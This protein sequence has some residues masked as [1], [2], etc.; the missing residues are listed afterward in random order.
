MTS[1]LIPISLLIRSYI[2]LP[3]AQLTTLTLYIYIVLLIFHFIKKRQITINFLNT[4]VIIYC[5]FALSLQI[6]AMMLSYIEITNGNLNKHPLKQIIVF[7][8][9]MIV[10][11]SYYIVVKVFI[12][13]IDDCRKFLKGIYYAFWIVMGV[14]IIQFIYL[15]T[16]GLKSLVTF[17]GQ[18][19]E[20]HFNRD[21]Y[22]SGSYVQTAGRINGF[23]PEASYLAAQL[24]I[25]FA[26]F[27]IAAIINKFDIFN[28]EKQYNSL[29]YFFMLGLILFFLFFGR[30]STGFVAIGVIIIFL[31]FKLKLKR[32]FIFTYALLSLFFILFIIFKDNTI[33]LEIFNHYL[34]EKDETSSSN[35]LGGT[36]ALILTWLNNFFFGT[37]YGYQDY[38]LFK[39]VPEWSKSNSEYQYVYLKNNY[40]PILSVFLGWFAQFGTIIMIFI[41]IYIFKLIRDI[42]KITKYLVN[43]VNVKYVSLLNTIKDS[44]NLFVI[45]YIVMSLLV[46]QWTD[47]YFI[48]VFFFF[49]VYRQL[50]K[51]YKN[52]ISIS[53]IK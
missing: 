44:A 2:P 10:I 26:P 9:L 6:I 34:F 52:Q 11:F 45:F 41:T 40:Y 33:V 38:Y 21:W 49:V 25:L 43:N 1:F 14:L 12:T 48:V 22:V 18:Y 35:R 47:A 3:V 8:I 32:K 53:N 42:N 37:G 29:K 7:S 5:F 51:G 13:N 27:I 28:W 19:L 20:A 16:G 30:S 39:Y 36:I 15:S 4:K 46:F 23:N 50:L 17:I 31:W 24:F